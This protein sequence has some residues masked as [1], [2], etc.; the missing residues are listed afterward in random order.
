MNIY[1]LQIKPYAP[2]FDI[3][4]QVKD[5]L[6]FMRRPSQLPVEDQVGIS[7]VYFSICAAMYE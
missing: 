4:S 2:M 6:W 7:S 1:D 5:V 3:T